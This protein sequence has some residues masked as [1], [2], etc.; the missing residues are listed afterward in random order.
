MG[1]DLIHVCQRYV[2]KVRE[3]LQY[4]QFS[5]QVYLGTKRWAVTLQ[6]RLSSAQIYREG[7]RGQSPQCLGSVAT[8]SPTIMDWQNS[9]KFQLKVRWYGRTIVVYSGIHA[10]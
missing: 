1:N 4:R 9:V 10:G 8:Y 2:K 5:T 3:V 7:Q 6:V